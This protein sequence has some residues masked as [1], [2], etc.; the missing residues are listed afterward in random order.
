MCWL[1]EHNNKIKQ[2]NFKSVGFCI[3][4]CSPF[5]QIL[6]VKTHNFA[7]SRWQKTQSWI[8][9]AAENLE[10]KSQE[11]E[12]NLITNAQFPSWFQNYVHVGITR[13]TALRHERSLKNHTAPGSPLLFCL[14]SPIFCVTQPAEKFSI[15]VKAYEYFQ[16]NIRNHAY[17]VKRNIYFN[18][19]YKP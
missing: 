1:I 9:I 3:C 2:K 15:K 11:W 5:Y 17:L 14:I 19:F 16:R 13:K 12:Q 4:R 18:T 6:Q 10:T 8:S 7:R